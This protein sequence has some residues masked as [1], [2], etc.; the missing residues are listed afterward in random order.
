M[1]QKQQWLYN[2]KIHYI[3]TFFSSVLFLA[4]IIT[5]YYK[6]FG[7]TVH[8]IVILSATFTL[9]ST[10]FEIPTSTL[11]DTIW[12]V[13]VMKISVLFSLFSMFLIFLFPNVIVFYIAVFFS[14]LWQALWSWTG[15]AKLQE[16]LQAS[17]NN[18]EKL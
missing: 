5:L 8:D 3:W 1:N 14:A 2:L 18:F 6:Y 11:W 7:L 12:R 9:F 13:K 4:P 10:L 15:H 17:N 16:D